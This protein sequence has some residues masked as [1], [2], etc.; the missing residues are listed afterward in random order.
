MVVSKEQEE[1]LYRQREKDIPRRWAGERRK[2][3]QN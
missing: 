3:S 1:K 2:S